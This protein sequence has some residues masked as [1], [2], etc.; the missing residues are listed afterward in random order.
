MLEILAREGSL[1]SEPGVKYDYNN[2]EY[3][4]LAQIVEKA[5]GK[6]FRDFLAE[7]IFKKI[8]MTHTM[9]YDETRP[10]IPDRAKGYTGMCGKYREIDYT[11]LNLVYGEDN[12]YTT[13]DD[14]YLWDQA[15]EKNELVKP[16]TLKE[17][18]TRGLLNDR[19]RCVYG[20]GWIIEPIV[21]FDA[22]WH[23]GWWAGSRSNLLRFPDRRFTVV[24]LAN[25]ELIDA[26]KVGQAI[27]EIYLDP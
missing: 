23:N 19:R 24:I 8:G 13:I 15:L 26:T 22:V 17:A 11:P 2:S 7:A 14:M 3:V 1:Q 10:V 20:F 16:E 25:C 4:V 5:S 21:G 18:F 12:I 9:L 6:H 27:A